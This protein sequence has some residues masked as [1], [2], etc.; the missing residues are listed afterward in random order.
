MRRGIQQCAHSTNHRRSAA[1]IILKQP[2]AGCALPLGIR[3]NTAT[4]PYE[5]EERKGRERERENLERLCPR[6]HHIGN[7]SPR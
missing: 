4:R 5:R 3:D 6:A 1:S 7:S 2:V